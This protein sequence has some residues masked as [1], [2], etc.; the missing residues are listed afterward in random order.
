MKLLLLHEIA[1]VAAAIALRVLHDI[2]AA[3]IAL[4][5]LHEIIAA[6]ALRVLHDAATDG[7]LLIFL[8]TNALQ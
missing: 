5:V 7:M 3:A 8:I 1:A 2:A 4:R 6:I